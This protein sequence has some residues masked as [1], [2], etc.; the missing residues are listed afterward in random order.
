VPA[1]DKPLAGR[2]ALIT[3]AS[4]GIGAAIARAYA[5][6]GAH[7]VL[8][9]RTVGGLEEVDDAIQADG[10]AATLVPLDLADGG[11]IDGLCASVWQRWRRLD[12][13]VGNAA[14]LGQ[15]GPIGHIPPDLWEQTFRINV[16][17]NWRLLRGCDA[18]LRQSD[19]GR[20]IFV[21]S[22]V[23]RDLPPYWGLYSA[24]KAALEALVRT[25]ARE[26]ASTAVR[27]NLVNPGPTR[28]AMRAAAFP[29]EAP[30][31]LPPP[32]HLCDT[33]I[34]LASPSFT[35]NGLWVAAD[36]LPPSRH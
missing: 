24:T 1:A 9:A 20:A 12:I 31:S 8:V 25:Y 28:T 4:R 34:R 17:A 10:G 14:L 19:A 11:A 26:V 32:E 13:L 3:G 6:A 15:L 29:G 23:T 16:H 33:L 22:G 30:E 27:A 35:G 5:R 2:L 36:Q 21:T 7:V 18:L